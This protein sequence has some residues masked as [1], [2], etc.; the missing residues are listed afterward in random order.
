M[1]SGKSTSSVF[2]YVNTSGPTP[3]CTSGCV[4]RRNF[5]TTLHEYL[6]S[7]S[8]TSARCT[9]TP[10]LLSLGC[11]RVWNHHHPFS[12]PLVPRYKT[13]ATVPRRIFSRRPVCCRRLPRNF[14]VLNKKIENGRNGGS[15]RIC[16]VCRRVV[17]CCVYCRIRVAQ[18][19]CRNRR[20]N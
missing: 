4:S 20:E 15:L 9:N 14:T 8:P 3:C 12:W 17:V 19:A 11:C 5:R 10:R 6:N 7:S 1:S 2:F 18:F 13:Y 16:V